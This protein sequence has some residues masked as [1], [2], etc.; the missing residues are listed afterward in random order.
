[1]AAVTFAAALNMNGCGVYGPPEDETD[2]Y[3]PDA[4]QNM[5]V[6]GPPEDMEEDYD[7]ETSDEVIA[8]E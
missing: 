4:N 5:E 8:D 3:E 6:Y 1:M 7:E 2:Y